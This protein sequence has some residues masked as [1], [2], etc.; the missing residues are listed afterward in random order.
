MTA[1]TTLYGNYVLTVNGTM[2]LV[3]NSVASDGTTA[4][5]YTIIVSDGAT[6]KT[7]GT[8]N[9]NGTGTTAGSV[10]TVFT[11]NVNGTLTPVAS[12]TFTSGN[13]ATSTYN[14]VGTAAKTS[15]YG[16]TF[17]DANTSSDCAVTINVTGT[18]AVTEITNGSY[19]D[20]AVIGTLTSAGAVNAKTMTVT[21]GTVTFGAASSVTDLIVTGA[22]IVTPASGSVSSVV[23]TAATAV[24]G[25]AS[26]EIADSINDATVIATIGTSAI[27]YGTA[28][29]VDLLPSTIVS[30][31]LYT[32][33]SDGN[34]LY[35]TEYATGITA[36]SLSVLTVTGQNFLGWYTAA[37]GG[38]V[39]TSN[40]SI[41]DYSSIYAL[42]NA[43]TYTVTF[44]YL[45]GAVYLVNGS[46]TASGQYTYAYG[47]DLT[48]SVIAASGYDAS[49]A[50]IQLNTTSPSTSAVTY[51]VDADATFTA[52]GVTEKTVSSSM[53]I[54]D[55]L[56][57]ILVVITAIV[58]IAVVLK[59]A[60]S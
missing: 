53:S 26:T 17:T 10:G 21:D 48:V 41:G 44:N 3:G 58:A 2:T 43:K 52:A 14:I 13:M 57:I 42:F 37:Q 31:A 35:A 36:L 11:L 38:S 24:I 54:T 8:F 7:S 22:A 59:L 23:L 49:K 30:T 28:A 19:L 51:T 55:I 60:R 20:V 27:V 46:Q 50:T 1:N 12:T 56:L 18:L 34:H 33:G 6:L 5:D 45:A 39:L 29:N 25:T 15:L 4:H 32:V 16:L 9:N 47:T 40:D